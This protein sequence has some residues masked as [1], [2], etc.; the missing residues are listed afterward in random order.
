MEVFIMP[1]VICAN[2]DCGKEYYVKPSLFEKG[3][4]KFCSRSCKNKVRDVEVKS[5]WNTI[6]AR[7]G[8]GKKYYVSPGKLNQGRGKY[9]SHEC[10]GLDKR[11]KSLSEEHKEKIGKATKQMWEDGVFD[12]PHI[13]DAYSKQGKSTK[14]S[15]RTKEQRKA[16]S[17]QR[18]GKVPKHLH[19]PEMKKKALGGRVGLKQSPESNKKRSESLKGREFSDE[20][21]KNLSE[22]RRAN[23]D[24]YYT[25][26]KGDD[27]P[28]WRDGASENPYPSEFARIRSEIKE[29][30]K[31]TCRICNELQ[32]GKRGV[33]HHID[34]DK[35]NNVPE[36]LI[37]LCMRCHGRIHWGRTGDPVILAFRSMLKY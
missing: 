26:P 32:E 33:V 37:L 31:N 29:R 23:S 34:A 22:S 5:R 10:Y 35:Q 28:N 19:T 16:L 30:D 8:C 6:C 21:R 1:R 25:F 36:N 15:K 27:N 11:G 18:K 7:E 14:G 20:H 3:H 13:R 17:D 4:K 24:K 2:L 9:C 12:A